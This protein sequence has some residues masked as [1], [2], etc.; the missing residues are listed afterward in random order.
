MLPSTV[1]HGSRIGQNYKFDQN[2]YFS[3]TSYLL[4]SYESNRTSTKLKV[5]V[6]TLLTHCILH[7]VFFLFTICVQTVKNRIVTCK[8]ICSMHKFDSICQQSSTSIKR[9]CFSLH[10]H[11]RNNCTHSNQSCVMHVL[12]HG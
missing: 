5:K 11:I 10:Y 4:Y 3:M 12:A 8:V 2:R 1:N 6:G 9:K 7:P